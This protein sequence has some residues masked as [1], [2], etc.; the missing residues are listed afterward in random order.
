MMN[1]HKMKR[2]IRRKKRI[3]RRA[4]NQAYVGG[5][6]D[7][8]KKRKRK[9]PFSIASSSFRKKQTIQISF[10]LLL[11]AAILGIYIFHPFFHISHI[12]V[13]GQERVTEQELIST[14]EASINKNRFF[15]FPGNSYIF[16]DVDEIDTILKE[17]FPIT[18]VHIEKN[19]PSSLSVNIA[20]RLST[21]IYDNADSYY[22]VGLNGN[23]IEPLRRVAESE[24]IVES[25]TTTS[26]NELG[27]EIEE[28]IEISRVHVP[29][30]H[31]LTTDVGAYPI[32]F[33]QLS[34]GEAEV[35]DHVLEAE[36]VANIVR[37]Y[38]SLD[39]LFIPTYFLLQSQELMIVHTK[40]G[41]D[42]YVDITEYIEP[43][44]NRLHIVLKE[45]GSGYRA[46]YID[47]R[48]AGRVYWQ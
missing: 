28:I 10:L 36:H 4:R 45:I 5:K 7:F 1:P 37:I 40:E 39:T 6:R 22:L 34:K 18:A 48:Y 13:D 47:V 26:T 35:N 21:I 2:K 8:A 12:M 16:I 44:L 42:L 15:I 17:K 29:D 3:Y 43:Q 32:I 11:L 20:E 23:I 14:V 30:I 33:D 38:Q 24:W 41:T 31:E 19:F 9:N 25:D 27:E 46:Q